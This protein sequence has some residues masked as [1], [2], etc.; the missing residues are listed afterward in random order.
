MDNA[1]GSPQSVNLSATVI[2]PKASFSPGSVAFGTHKVGAPS[3]SSVTLT[4]TGATPLTISSISVAG[5]NASDFGVTNNCPASLVAGKACT[6]SVGFTPTKTGSR[7]AYVNV[8]DNMQG[9][10]QQI[11][12]SG[13]GN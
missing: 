9:G 5:T 13:T 7:T 3:S 4:N 8:V 2:N 1:P 10:S 12:L 11:P 6:I